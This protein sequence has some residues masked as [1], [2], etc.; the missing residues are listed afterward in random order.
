MQKDL[1]DLVF[2]AQL[3]GP[4]KAAL[5][6]DMS[7]EEVRDQLERFDYDREKFYKQLRSLICAQMRKEP[8]V[9]AF[10]LTELLAESLKQSDERGR[11]KRLF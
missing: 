7:E 1:H 10:G 5:H 6:F 3:A 9:R 4:R 8:E 2:Y 11:T